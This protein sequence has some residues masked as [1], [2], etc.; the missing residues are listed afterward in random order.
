MGESN[1]AGVDGARQEG[2][3]HTF[4]KF[5]EGVERPMVHPHDGELT[6][7]E[8]AFSKEFQSWGGLNRLVLAASLRYR[9]DIRDDIAARFLVGDGLEIGAQQVPTKVNPTR[10]R[11]EYV[12]R[13]T[14]DETSVRFAIPRELLVHVTHVSDGAK[15]DSVA[16]R[17]KDFLIANHVLEHFDDPIG[18]VV[19]WLR[20]LK[21]GGMLF[22]SLP[23]HLGNPFDFRRRPPAINHLQ[24]DFRDRDYRVAN[25]RL[26]YADM[27]RTI[28]DFEASNPLILATADEWIRL[29]ERHHYHVYD[30]K[31]LCGILSEAA[32]HVGAPLSVEC[33]FSPSRGYE[34]LLVVKKGPPGNGR[35]SPLN[36]VGRKVA[37][38]SML[39]KFVAQAL[40]KGDC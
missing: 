31:T 13:L 7:W 17:S 28:Y 36:T 32:Q 15:L 39:Y 30:Y 2:L 5:R 4:R 20:V 23:N 21:P 18:G 6:P 10:A 11:I 1:L 37:A 3:R 9:L 8:I 29:E 19:E 26:H 40:A 25:N 34:I 35:F 33:D 12:D 16:D 27:V 14:A 38:A 22:L 24:R